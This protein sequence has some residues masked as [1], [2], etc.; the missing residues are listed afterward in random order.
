MD[1]SSNQ[2]S[3]NDPIAALLYIFAPLFTLIVILRFRLWENP[4]M[5]FGFIVFVLSIF[6]SSKYLWGLWNPT[7]TKEE[8]QAQKHQ[9]LEVSQNAALAMRRAG[10]NALTSPL[11]LIDIGLLV[12]EGDDKP[13]VYRTVDIGT[14]ATYIRPFIVVDIENVDHYATGH[15]TIRFDII[16]E[17]GKVRFANRSRYTVKPGQNF[18][19]PQMW[20][21]VQGLNP[22]GKWTIHVN[23]GQNNLFAIHEFEW[24]KVGGELRAQFTG[25]GEIDWL[26]YDY[27][28]AES[29]SLD[30]LLAHQGEEAP[31]VVTTQ[32]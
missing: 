13:Q 15:G 20:L 19:T 24:F 2:R 7:K 27:P 17:H 9:L 29:L 4:W 23:V 25:D 3:N 6:L 28:S 16:D 5:G 11:R 30:E 14:D 8:I 12:Y 26:A 18:I 22:S 31:L 21:P 10:H 32:R 1:M